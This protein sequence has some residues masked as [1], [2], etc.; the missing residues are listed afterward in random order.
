MKLL[1][2]TEENV[3]KIKI[4][5]NVQFIINWKTSTHVILSTTKKM[6]ILGESLLYP[7]SIIIIKFEEESFLRE[8]ILLSLALRC[9]FLICK[10]NH[11]GFISNHNFSSN[12]IIHI[13]ALKMDGLQKAFG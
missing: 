7:L 4:S 8:G 2:V 6:H 5:E 13:V 11:D 10:F 3:T 9:P 1:G 12:F